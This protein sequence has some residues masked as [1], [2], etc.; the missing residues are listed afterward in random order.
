M[1]ISNFLEKS[2]YDAA[3]GATGAVLSGYFLKRWITVLSPMN[4]AV[5]MLAQTVA[6]HV[7][8]RLVGGKK[9]LGESD[10]LRRLFSI[11][12]G[13][14]IAT[15]ATN[16]TFNTAKWTFVSSFIISSFIKGF[17]EEMATD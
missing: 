13:I 4:G 1:N 14:C 16:I 15:R 5:Y 6:A 3:L 9:D 11:F 10:K 2:L 8:N 7:L 12:G 17:L